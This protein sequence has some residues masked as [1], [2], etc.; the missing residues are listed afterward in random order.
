VFSEEE[1]L[2]GLRL[3]T[4][5]DRRASYQLTFPAPRDLSGQRLRI[6]M[7]G[8]A[9]LPSITARAFALSRNTPR[10]ALAEGGRVELEDGASE[11]LLNLDAPTS[12]E[13][14]FAPG[15]VETLGVLLESRVASEA[16]IISVALESNAE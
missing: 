10:A 15:R 16:Q 13:E 5:A 6:V 14:G 9:E 12:H 11:L 7:A 1:F 2:S 4:R 3:T 8:F